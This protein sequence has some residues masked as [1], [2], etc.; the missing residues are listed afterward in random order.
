LEAQALGVVLPDLCPTEQE[1]AAS[2]EDFLELRRIIRLGSVAVSV[3]NKTLEKPLKEKANFFIGVDDTNNLEMERRE[4]DFTAA[5]ASRRFEV[6][7][8]T[9]TVQSC[10]ICSFSAP[11]RDVFTCTQG[12]YF[13]DNHNARKFFFLFPTQHQGAATPIF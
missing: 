13:R 3:L 11:I 1:N 9:V 10:G 8:M 12:G 5:N 7:D 6:D 2:W 4:L